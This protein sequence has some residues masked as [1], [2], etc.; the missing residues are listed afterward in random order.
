MRG[1]RAGGV[2]APVQ[3]SV[4]DEARTKAPEEIIWEPVRIGVVL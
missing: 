4:A 2:G 1:Q 3:W